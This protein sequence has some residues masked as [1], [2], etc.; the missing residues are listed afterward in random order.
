MCQIKTTN[1][2]KEKMIREYKY[3]D[4]M[5]QINVIISDITKKY[6]DEKNT[7]ILTTKQTFRSLVYKSL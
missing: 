7:L 3:N 4:E 6:N 2:N 1:S 5:R